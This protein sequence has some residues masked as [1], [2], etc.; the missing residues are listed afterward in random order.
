M[1][2]LLSGVDKSNKINEITFRFVRVN[3]FV[4]EVLLWVYRF[5]SS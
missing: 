3:L 1:T 2:L 5:D 4:L